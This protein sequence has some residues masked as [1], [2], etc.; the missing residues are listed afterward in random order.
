MKT[1]EEIVREGGSTR[2]AVLSAADRLGLRGR[3]IA[4]TTLW[5]DADADRILAA[6]AAEVARDRATTTTK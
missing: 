2:L 3:R 6:L 5:V 1:I 4:G